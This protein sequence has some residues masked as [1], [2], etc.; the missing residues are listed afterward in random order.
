M[1]IPET[2]HNVE[3]VLD[4][5]KAEGLVF[6]GRLPNVIDFREATGHTPATAEQVGRTIWLWDQPTGRWSVAIAVKPLEG[7]NDG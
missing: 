3:D 4:Y 6:A 2:T 7:G 1:E 5:L